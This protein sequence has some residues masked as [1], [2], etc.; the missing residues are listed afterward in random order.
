MFCFGNKLFMFTIQMAS[1]HVVSSSYPIQYA[2]NTQK[3]KIMCEM[4]VWKIYDDD[5]DSSS[6]HRKA[7]NFLVRNLNWCGDLGMRNVIPI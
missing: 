5:G 2:R 4:C 6:M 1:A 7:G 3:L